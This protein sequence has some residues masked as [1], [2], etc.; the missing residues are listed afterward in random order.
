VWSEDLTLHGEIGEQ[1]LIYEQQ[2]I[3]TVENQTMS[4]GSDVQQTGSLVSGINA[5]FV[6]HQLEGFGFLLNGTYL[7]TVLAN[8][9]NQ[10]LVSLAN[11]YGGQANADSCDIIPLGP[12]LFAL[13]DGS[14][15]VPED[16]F[17]VQV[18]AIPTLNGITPSVQIWIRST[19]TILAE[20]IN[21]PTRAF[22]AVGIQSTE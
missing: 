12:L 19:E 3:T 9:S 21:I 17:F 14:N 7:G 16:G 5:L 4:D 8:S 13:G 1:E 10:L 20:P 22:V 18:L 2:T 11:T 6:A 15:I